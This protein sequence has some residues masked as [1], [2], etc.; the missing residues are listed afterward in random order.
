VSVLLLQGRPEDEAAEE[1]YRA[2]LSRG[3]L[4]EA[5]VRRVRLERDDP[6][7]LE[8]ARAVILGGGPACV[9]DPPDTVPAAEARIA[10]RSAAVVAEAAARD[11]PFL[12]LCY[13]IGALAAHLGARVDKSAGAE[14]ISAA[15]LTVTEDGRADP[16]LAG[17]PDSFTGL[18]AHKEAVQELPAGAVHLVRGDTCPF[19]MIRH[20]RHV[21]ATQFHPEADGASFAL[22]IRVYADR[23][24]FAPAEAAQLIDRIGAVK[25]PH[26]GRILRNF[27][28]RYVRPA[29]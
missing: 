19:H 23:G 25:T 7:P 2:I 22:R 6:P 9:S 13:G 16:I 26:A 10:A 28:E 21:Y 18:T 11:L 20:G 27:I 12:G 17:V 5:Q 4:T 29:R 8:G 14:P 1:E 15:P 3:G 24:Y